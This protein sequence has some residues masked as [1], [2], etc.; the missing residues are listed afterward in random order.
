MK[1]K[2]MLTQEQRKAKKR[3]RMLSKN[4]LQ[5]GKVMIERVPDEKGKRVYTKYVSIEKAS[6]LVLNFENKTT[7]EYRYK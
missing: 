7:K 1:I 3:Q 4:N 5:K 6:R 2:K